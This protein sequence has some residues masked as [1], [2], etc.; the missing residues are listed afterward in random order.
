MNARDLPIEIV[1]HIARCL[2]FHGMSS[3]ALTCKLWYECYLF[4][5]E[6]NSISSSILSPFWQLKHSGRGYIEIPCQ[7]SPLYR[8]KDDFSMEIRVRARSS[9]P[10]IVRESCCVTPPTTD[11]SLSQLYEEQPK[12]NLKIYFNTDPGRLRTRV[13]CVP[14]IV[15]RNEWC[16]ISISFAQPCLLI[17]IDGKLVQRETYDNKVAIITTPFRIGGTPEHSNHKLA[18][19][20]DADLQEVRFWNHGRTHKEIE[21]NSDRILHGKE[22]GLIAY[23]YCNG[24]MVS[25]LTTYH[26]TTVVHGQIWHD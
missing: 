3:F 2:P 12:L 23:Y 13:F 4:R 24:E 18:G 14:Y 20:I 19:G 1:T 26:H 22:Q 25:D 11:L 16:L 17:Y 10:L 8:F 9:G 7:I 6:N 21:Q 5:S 15:P